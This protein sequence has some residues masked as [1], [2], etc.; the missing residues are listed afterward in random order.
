MVS[1]KQAN[2]KSIAVSQIVLILLDRLTGL[3]VVKSHQ[4]TPRKIL[5]LKEDFQFSLIYLATTMIET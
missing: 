3:V 1:G 5:E 2:T 4:S